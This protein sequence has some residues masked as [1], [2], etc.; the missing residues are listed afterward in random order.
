MALCGS[1]A[2]RLTFAATLDTVIRIR[3]PEPNANSTGVPPRSDDC[4]VGASVEAI[5]GSGNEAEFKG[6]RAE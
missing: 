6:L 2:G 5:C 3:P 1:V 4:M